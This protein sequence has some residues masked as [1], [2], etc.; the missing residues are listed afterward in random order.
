MRAAVS[1][2]IFTAWLPV[3]TRGDAFSKPVS[4]RAALADLVNEDSIMRP[5]D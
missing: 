3:D 5:A 2:D 4:H 1:L